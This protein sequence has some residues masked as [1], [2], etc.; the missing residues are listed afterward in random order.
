MATVRASGGGRTVP[1]GEQAVLPGRGRIVL[2]V[3]PPPG[4]AFADAAPFEA[5][6]RVRSGPAPAAATSGAP[7]DASAGDPC[8]S[9]GGAVH[10]DP[11]SRSWIREHPVFP[12]EI[13]VRFD[14][15]RGELEIDLVA[16]YCEDRGSGV[17][18]YQHVCLRIAV[19]VSAEAACADIEIVYRLGTPEIAPTM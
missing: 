13:P 16:Y 10:L 14:L 6:A 11:E 4:H 12:C 17:C 19:V 3:E 8:G 7:L 5:R 1:L 9:P 18:Y 2:W 15:G